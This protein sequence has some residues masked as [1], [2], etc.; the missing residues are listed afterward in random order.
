MNLIDL[1]F[2]YAW[3]AS[4][5][6]RAARLRLPPGSLVWVDSGAFTAYTTGK[7]LDVNEYA[8]HLLNND[9]GWDYAFT[10]D[11][12][13]DP[14]ATRANTEALA[15]RGLDTIPVFHFGDGMPNWVSLC[16][17]YGYLAIGGLV[18]VLRRGAAFVIPYVRTLTAVAEEHGCAVHALGC[19]GVNLIV[20]ARVFSADS[21]TVSSSP[22]SSSLAFYDGRRMRMV[23]TA[24]TAELRRLAPKLARYGF[25][26]AQVAAERRWS[27]A[28][29]TA[30][31]KVS[32]LSMAQMWVDVRQRHPLPVP[33]RLAL[34]R[35]GLLEGPGPRYAS[36]LVKS[37]SDQLLFG[38]EA[39][40][41]RDGPIGSHDLKQEVP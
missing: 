14:V 10:L 13:G 6:H 25:P 29:R 12:I 2:S 3:H 31:F 1:L 15:A 21:S 36:A 11:V 40:I 8:D 23:G 35:V 16:R 19:G 32:L 24:D 28:T 18:P 26:T 34:P 7:H 17:D 20:Q 39:I 22:L 37:V 30:L 33:P 27:V 5:D 9:G 4:T 38:P 41:P